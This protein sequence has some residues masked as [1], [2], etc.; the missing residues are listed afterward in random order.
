MI[1]EQANAAD[2]S[3]SPFGGEGEEDTRITA[4]D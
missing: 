1:E 2:L 3:P 4:C